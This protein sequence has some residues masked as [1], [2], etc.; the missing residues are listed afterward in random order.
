MSENTAPEKKKSSSL[1]AIVILL[2]IGLAVM[3]YLWS[4]KN[5]QLN[6]CMNE[7]KQ[8]NA[9]MQGMNEMMSGYLGE[10]SNDMKKDF[11]QMLN[12][13]D[14]LL[15]KDASMSD[16]INSQKEKIT[17]L[18]N[19]VENGKMTAHQLFLAKKEIETMRKIMRGYIYQ[20]DSLNTLNLTLRSDLETTQTELSGT[21]A[22]RDEYRTQAEQS[23]EQVKKGSKLTAYGFETVGLKEKLNSTMDETDRA[24]N[25]VQIRSSFTIGKNPITPAG[26]KSVYLQ[27]IDPSG[28]TLQHSSASVL[29]TD[30]GQVPFS[31]K[32][33]I[34]YQNESIDMSIYFS[35]R[36][37]QLNKGNYKV[38]IYC[39]GQLIGSDSFTLK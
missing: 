10:M 6:T 5:S 8:L 3:A 7:N 12:A 25:V 20:I 14:A 18:M 38:N 2:M 26:K 15:D 34:D 35:L 19:Q 32:K 33:E 4:S 28:K 13:Y 1:T 37:I 17:E 39:Q 30:N 16:S 9:D 22:E 29:D 21:K 23:A 31:D 11:K 36:N 24:K 27:V